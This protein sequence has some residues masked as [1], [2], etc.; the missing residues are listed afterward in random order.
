MKNALQCAL[1]TVIATT[2]AAAAAVLVQP[3]SFENFE[4][5]VSHF[6]Q[7][8]TF[9]TVSSPQAANHAVHPGEHARLDHWLASTYHSVWS[10]FQVQKVMILVESVLQSCVS[11]H[12]VM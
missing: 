6:S 9:N 12:L 7:F 10:S 8:L 4:L 5:A 11:M 2:A 3:C 1:F